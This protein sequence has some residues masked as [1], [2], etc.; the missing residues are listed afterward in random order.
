MLN[1]FNA[2]KE[3]EEEKKEVDPLRH[4]N[5]VRVLYAFSKYEE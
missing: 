5:C 2:N 1:T 3:R 4:D